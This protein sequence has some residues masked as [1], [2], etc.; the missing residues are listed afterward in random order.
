MK[1]SPIIKQLRCLLELLVLLIL[2]IIGMLI[3]N[4]IP[5]AILEASSLLPGYSGNESVSYPWI[6]LIDN[7]LLAIGT[8]LAVFLF[9]AIFGRSFKEVGFSLKGRL[10]DFGWGL[11]YGT[12]A[13]LSGFLILWAIGFIAI[14]PGS[15]SYLSVL[16]CF[17][18]FFFVALSEELLCRGAMISIC[19]KYQKK[20]VALIVPSLIFSV[21]HIFN[22]GFDWISFGNIFLAGIFLGIYYVFHRNLWF[23]IAL[24]LAWNFVQGPVLG[25]AVSGTS[26]PELITQTQHGSVLWTGGVFG[27][28]GSLLGLIILSVASLAVYFHFRKAPVTIEATD[29]QDVF[30]T[31]SSD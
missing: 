1:N 23:P 2:W 4:G 3:F 12:G 24:H 22:G 6:N 27:F 18:T 20:I 25:F 17:L 13:I 7:I 15:A 5:R 19:L 14:E 31:P 21:M 9:F 28:E 30:T 16:A 11:A 26:T 8:L 10:K 29:E